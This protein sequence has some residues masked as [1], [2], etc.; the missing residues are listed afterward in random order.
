MSQR[1]P[2]RIYFKRLLAAG[3][4][5]GA[6]ELIA[7]FAQRAPD[8]PAPAGAQIDRVDPASL[9]ASTSF[10]WTPE[11]GFD[12]TPGDPS[13][14]RIAVI[15]DG[16]TRSPEVPVGAHWP[17]LLA[18]V[19]DRA[20]GF[21][22]IDLR[23]F[24][25]PGYSAA[26]GEAVLGRV[27]ESFQP[28]VV[29]FQ[30]GNGNEAEFAIGDRRDE[31]WLARPK[32]GT[33]LAHS[34]LARL[35]MP[36]FDD[37]LRKR[38]TPPGSVRQDRSEFEVCVARMIARTREYGAI[39]ALMEPVVSISFESRS[40]NADILEVYRLATAKV[41]GLYGVP[42][43]NLRD[44]M[45]LDANAF[46]ATREGWSERGH[47]VAAR[48]VFRTLASDPALLL[49]LRRWLAQAPNDPRRQ[50]IAGAFAVLHAMYDGTL[51]TSPS[52][53]ALEPLVAAR[54]T[55]PTLADAI[56]PLLALVRW[57]GAEL[58]TVPP[59]IESLA[60][61]KPSARTTCIHAA[62]LVLTGRGEEARTRLSAVETEDPRLAALVQ[63]VRGIS[64][65]SSDAPEAAASFQ[66]AIDLDPG[67][68]IPELWLAK[69][70]V[71]NG[72]PDSGRIA[73]AMARRMLV[74]HTGTWNG[75]ALSRSEDNGSIDASLRDEP[76][77]F[78]RDQR[79]SFGRLLF[80]R[81]IESVVEAN[82]EFLLLD[83]H[84]VLRRVAPDSPSA[85]DTAEIERRAESL[86]DDRLV[87]LAI[88]A[89]LGSDLELAH[90]FGERALE[91]RATPQAH[92]ACAIIEFERHE[93]QKVIAHI[94]AIE[95]WSDDAR[96]TM[97]MA[98]SER[99]I[100]NPDRARAILE[101]ARKRWP[102]RKDVETLLAEL[103]AAE[104]G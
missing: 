87:A 3:L 40:A 82:D 14:L 5:V 69:L 85:S 58:E 22:A 1:S 31:E 63:L 94:G 81:D 4:L 55:D 59:L 37:A 17:D 88:A 66:R 29:V 19:I 47:R 15:G 57:N 35:V 49:T 10:L 56:A 16:L 25:A 71:L 99:E 12:L 92:R 20:V 101:E 86:P 6:L 73:Y 18:R 102:T 8:P 50:A 64:L 51:A 65:F 100:G 43:V 24:A 26:Q 75:F 9:R 90:R 52:Q 28:N 84:L 45:G 11:A 42:F 44:A 60:L 96:L 33:L 89:L 39:A 54:R 77:L 41:A 61:E 98:R 38:G 48:Q 30:L 27:L 46:L 76:T 67:L 13:R 83:R 21:P 7:R 97:L 68:G 104:S 74:S 95:R 80:L 79:E 62:A 103:D 78:G 36:W 72:D 2:L 34:A 32:P 91:K 53:S 93:P 23:V 70:R